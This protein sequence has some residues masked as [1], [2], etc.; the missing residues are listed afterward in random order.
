MDWVIIILYGL[1]ALVALGAA[2][3]VLKQE[4]KDLSQNLF[5]TLLLFGSVSY[6]LEGFSSVSVFVECLAMVIVPMVF[7]LAFVFLS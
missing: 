6:L 5:I 3:I 1:P 4:D 7:P 2:S